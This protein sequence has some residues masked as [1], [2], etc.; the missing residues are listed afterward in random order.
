MIAMGG[1]ISIKFC[2]GGYATSRL[3]DMTVEARVILVNDSDIIHI[4]GFVFLTP[5]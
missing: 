4:F 2:A 3:S 5:C 1:G